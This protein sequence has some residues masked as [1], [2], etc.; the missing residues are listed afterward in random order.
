MI[1]KRLRNNRLQERCAIRGAEEVPV[2]KNE[3]ETRMLG[4]RSH[5]S[6]YA[7]RSLHFALPYFAP[8]RS[9]KHQISAN[10]V[11]HLKKI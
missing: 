7:V 10:I 5:N 8:L 6:G 4:Q 11:L 9:A 2:S 1:V 3:Y